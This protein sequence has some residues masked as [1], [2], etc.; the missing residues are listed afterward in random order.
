MAT[1][2]FELSENGL[3]RFNMDLMDAWDVIS[4]SIDRLEMEYD[5]GACVD[6]CYGDRYCLIRTPDENVQIFLSLF[7][8]WQEVW[9]EES[10]E[11]WLFWEP[12]M[13]VGSKPEDVVASY[14]ALVS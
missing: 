5:T 12:G 9:F 14:R 6:T 2:Y 7:G 11:T 4:D 1:M 3:E 13:D 8:L 10:I